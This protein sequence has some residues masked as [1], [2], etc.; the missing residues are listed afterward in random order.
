MARR[1]SKKTRPADRVASGIILTCLACIALVVYLTGHSDRVSLV[2]VADS[3]WIAGMDLAPE[4]IDNRSLSG[5]RIYTP[6]NLYEYIDGQAPHY[7]GF[8]FRALLVAEYSSESEAIPSLVVELYD[9]VLR[10]NAYGLFMSSV[11]PEDELISLGNSGYASGNTAS[12]WKGPLFVKVNGLTSTD[13]GS[14]VSKAAEAVADKIDDGSTSLVEFDAFPKEGLIPDTLAYSKSAAFGLSYLTDTFYASYET[15]TGTYRLFFCDLANPAEA[16]KILKDHAE[17]LKSSD[18]LESED[19]QSEVKSV[20]GKDKYVGPTLFIARDN[21]VA[22]STGLADLKTARTPCSRP[23]QARN[24]DRTERDW[25][26]PTRWRRMRSISSRHRNT[27]AHAESSCGASAP[28]ARPW[29]V[30]AASAS[31]STTVFPMRD[32]G[33]SHFPTTGWS[34][35]RIVRGSLPRR[36]EIL[37]R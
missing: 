25:G 22:G 4:K 31:P 24:P 34:T 16:E 35:S 17:F 20:W 33:Q 10:R 27:T 21:F 2:T 19:Y 28:P 26:G 7:I 14:E 1:K 37:S 30:S 11:P 5:T 29:P 6:E 13:M 15:P 3:P 23:A 8:G 32:R 9:M 18:G 36:G 12:F